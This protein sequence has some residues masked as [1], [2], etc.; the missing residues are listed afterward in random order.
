[1]INWISKNNYRNALFIAIVAVIIVVGYTWN[2]TASRSIS[3][4]H[5]EY[6]FYK[7]SVNIP[8][9]S[10]TS[11]WLDEN[12]KIGQDHSDNYVMEIN[13]AAYTTP[14]WIHPLA[15]N[16]ISYPV[17]VAIIN[18]VDQIWW[19]HLIVSFIIILTVV[20]F[21]LTIK[22]LTNNIIASFS[23]FPIFL[24]CMLMLNGIIWYHDT[25]MWLFFSIALFYAVRCS[26][27]TILFTILFVLSKSNAF[28]LLIPIG[29]L[30]W[31]RKHQFPYITLP[32]LGL[33]ACWFVAQVI[34]TSDLLFYF[35]HF[36]GTLSGFAGMFLKE[37]QIPRIGILIVSWSLWLY[38]PII[39][40]GTFLI[41]KDKNKKFYPF[42]FLTAFILIFGFGW[43]WFGYHVFPIIYAS[44]F[45]M[46]AI[47]EKLQFMMKSKVIERI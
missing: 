47:I 6:I 44:I 46:P 20:M 16:Y 28:I 13:Q 36:S 33:I 2:S 5:D 9:V 29:I 23:V 37:V 7:L 40:L 19:L 38:I 31:Q 11:D 14:M 34:I 41:V 43:G 4:T 21:M 30:W 1:M 18:P 25:F 42:L 27:W 35:H 8:S 39:I 32:A 26:K 3:M 22:E 24:S 10:T 45:M 12:P 15:A 17:N